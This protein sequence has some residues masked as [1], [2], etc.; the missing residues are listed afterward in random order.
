MQHPDPETI[1]A[2]GEAVGFIVASLG[3]AI[4]AILNARRNH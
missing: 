2:I 1:K 4:A 3:T